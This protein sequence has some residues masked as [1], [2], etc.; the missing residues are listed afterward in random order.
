MGSLLRRE[1]ASDPDPF[2]HS[3]TAARRRRGKLK[4]HHQQSLLAFCQYFFFICFNSFSHPPPVPSAPSSIPQQHPRYRVRSQSPGVCRCQCWYPA[5]V[6]VNPVLTVP[7]H[8]RRCDREAVP[9]K[10]PIMR[11]ATGAT[12]SFGQ[13][14]YIRPGGRRGDRRKRNKII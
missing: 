14:G 2:V 5:I 11:S 13:V 4:S 1:P 8:R 10:I 7:Y 12:N 9:P 3:L 6:G